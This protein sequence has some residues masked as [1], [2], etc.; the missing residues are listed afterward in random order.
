[1]RCRLRVLAGSRLVAGIG[2]PIAQFCAFF[3][4]LDWAIWQARSLQAGRKDRRDGRMAR[5]HFGFGPGSPGCPAG[6][7]PSPGSACSGWTNRPCVSGGF[8]WDT[9]RKRPLGSGRGSQL[10]VPSLCRS[11]TALTTVSW[12]RRARSPA[13]GASPHVQAIPADVGAG[14]GPVSHHLAGRQADT[15]QR[16][17]FDDGW[18]CR[19]EGPTLVI[20]HDQL[21][22]GTNRREPGCPVLYAI[23]TLSFPAKR[24]GSRIPYGPT[25]ESQ[26]D[27]HTV[28]VRL[29]YEPFRRGL[30][31][32][33]VF[34]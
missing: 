13:F 5:P 22:S 9:Q 28:T 27:K 14:A 30:W 7:P 25:A 26:P 8:W 16:A 31:T 19:G 18:P 1:M 23:M 2:A 6:G 15:T 10:H 11:R 34:C 12:R 29:I 17:V 20:S 32:F 24:P 3:S 4:T 21:P 33:S